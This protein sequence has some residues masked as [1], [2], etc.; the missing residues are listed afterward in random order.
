MIHT[1]EVFHSLEF[2]SKR[3]VHTGIFTVNKIYSITLYKLQ[4]VLQRDNI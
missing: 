2:Q 1:V 4:T 3:Y